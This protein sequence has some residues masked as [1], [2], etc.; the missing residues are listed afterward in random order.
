MYGGNS[1][2]ITLEH[3][4][5]NQHKLYYGYMYGTYHSKLTIDGACLYVKLLFS[6]TILSTVV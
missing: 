3:I 5:G 4:K 2:D 6:H 1:D